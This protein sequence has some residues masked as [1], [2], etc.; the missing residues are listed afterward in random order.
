MC[1]LTAVY[2]AIN[3]EAELRA[4]KLLGMLSAGRGEDSTGI[5]D[6]VPSLKNEPMVH[7]EKFLQS[8][9]TVF[10]PG[11]SFDEKF[12]WGRYV[13][14]KEG[15]NKKNKLVYYFRMYEK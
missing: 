6:Y 7:V 10:T 5:F 9:F 12:T 13:R 4:F 14:K 15:S 8:P 11:K 3:K 2:G 1:G